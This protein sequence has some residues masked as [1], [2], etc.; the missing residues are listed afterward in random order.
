MDDE[1]TPGTQGQGHTELTPPQPPS[2]SDP[3]DSLDTGVGIKGGFRIQAA[4]TRP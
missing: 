2:T 4:T 3:S 1:E